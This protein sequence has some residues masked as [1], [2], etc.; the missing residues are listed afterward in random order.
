MAL[1]PRT[2]SLAVACA[3]MLASAPAQTTSV[4]VPAGFDGGGAGFNNLT[5]FGAQRRKFQ[6]IYT[7]AGFTSR[8]IDGPILIQRLRYRI[9]TGTSFAT[10]IPYPG[11]RLRMSTTSVLPSTMSTTFAANHGADV[12]T[13]FTGTVNTI[14]TTPSVPGGVHVDILL[15]TPFLYYPGPGRHLCIEHKMNDP[16]N[17]VPQTV[18]V[19]AANGRHLHNFNDLPTGI[20]L[21]SIISDTPVNI[22]IVDFVPAPGTAWTNSYGAGCNTP[23]LRLQAV[24]RPLLGS[25]QVLEIRQLPANSLFA[26]LVAGLAPVLPPLDL[27]GIGMAGCFLHARIDVSYGLFPAAGIAT[28]SILL[29]VDSALVGQSIFTQGAA[30]A[31]ATNALE[32]VSSN[33]IELVLGNQ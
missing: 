15:A 11:Y 1:I 24:G 18:G 10:P 9:A 28:G 25:T 16:L 17:S 13:V 12:A 32:L 4:I 31:P 23:P 29:P 14:P 3:A 30:N 6:D 2:P 21:N 22:A 19:E 8:G 27:S 7:A 5:T 20:I 33:A 26:V